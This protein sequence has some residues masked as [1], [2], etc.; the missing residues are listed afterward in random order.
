M[1]S[2]NA[3]MHWFKN[4]GIGDDDFG[5]VDTSLSEII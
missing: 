4:E 1:K 5:E 2:I 3:F